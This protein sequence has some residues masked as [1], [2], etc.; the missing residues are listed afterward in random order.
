VSGESE[1]M[2]IPQTVSA[3]SLFRTAAGK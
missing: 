3:E 1:G 2:E